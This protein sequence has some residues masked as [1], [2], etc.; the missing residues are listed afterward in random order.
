MTVPRVDLSLDSNVLLYTALL[1]AAACLMFGLLPAFQATSSDLSS[2][3]KDEGALWGRRVSKA[4]LRGALV[5]VQ[6]T[7]SMALLLSTGLLVRGIVSV[8]A[9]SDNRH[10]D[11]YM[12]TT[13][14]LRAHRYSAARAAVFQEGLRRQLDRVPGAS[15]AIT[16]LPPFAGV[17][18]RKNNSALRISTIRAMGRNVRLTLRSGRIADVTS[19]ES[20]RNNVT[21]LSA[22]R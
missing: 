10:L 11:R 5:A 17:V 4:R 12:V 6:V 2:A 19:A 9:L 21:H 7:I 13:L 15:T 22:T 1:S 16:V 8:Q 20:R 18:V 3:L 14:D